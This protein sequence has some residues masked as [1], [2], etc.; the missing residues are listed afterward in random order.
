MGEITED[1]RTIV[2]PDN[3]KYSFL[4]AWEYDSWNRLISMHYPDG[5]ELNYSYNSGGQMI[6]MSGK[7]GNNSYEYVNFIAYDKFGNRKYIAYGNGTQTTY[8]YDPA[9]LR[10]SEPFFR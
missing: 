3:C 10:F 5:E 7:K 1:L 9:N 8:N 6:A 2:V 4:T